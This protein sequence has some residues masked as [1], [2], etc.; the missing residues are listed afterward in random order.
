VIPDKESTPVE[1]EDGLQTA[2]TFSP[3]THSG[4]TVPVTRVGPE[5]SPSLLEVSRNARSHK[6]SVAPGYLSPY[7]LIFSEDGEFTDHA[8]SLPATY[9]SLDSPSPSI[10][11]RYNSGHRQINVSYHRR[12]Y[13]NVPN[14]SA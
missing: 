3:S 14:G 9:S 10:S 4:Q 7:E 1:S 5:I 2:I 11:D 13:K 8:S 12:S 6:A